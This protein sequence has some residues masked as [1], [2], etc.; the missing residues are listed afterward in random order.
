MS[1][2]TERRIRVGE[3]T[4]PFSGWLDRDPIAFHAE[5]R[6]GR[7][8]AVELKT[9]E[10]LTY[11][12]LD[13]RV[14]R[15][16]GWLAGKVP[17]PL[18]QR[19]AFLG[20]SSINQLCVLFACHRLGA[21]FQPLNWRLTGPEIAGLVEDGTPSLL[22][23]DSE[24]AE[25]AR[26]ALAALPGLAA[27]KIEGDGQALRADILASAPAAA[28]AVDPHAPFVILYTSG[29]TGKPK[30]AVITRINGFFGAVNFSA[31]G[32]VTAASA[33][34][35]DAPMFH[36]VGLM[37]VART[38]MQQ[39][40]AML[41]ADRLIPERTLDVITDR[42]FGVSHYFAVPQIAQMLRDHPAYARSDLTG[43]TGL[44]TGGAPMPTSLTSAFLDD[45][46][47]VSNG[48]GMT[49]VGTVM[50]M[51]LDIGLVRQRLERSGL[52]APTARL[53]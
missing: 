3:G 38:A 2:A 46:V 41:I 6:P 7:L 34:L 13:E 35:C 5:R 8:A 33:M 30:G 45:G 53:R 10:R 27:Y 19:I 20:R 26:A 51:P 32:Q 25:A 52:L 12:E 18:G 49:E 43:L 39:G 29:T 15:T 31:V 21:I 44:F 42:S 47:T 11:A 1:S 40:A 23:Y 14:A 37:A 17:S 48:Y 36:T 4:D 16:A 22:L 9:D 28:A 24:F 50:H